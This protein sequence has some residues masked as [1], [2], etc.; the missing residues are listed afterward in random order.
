MGGADFSERK[1]A[2]VGQAS[3]CHQIFSLSHYPV[4]RLGL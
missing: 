1:H 3:A 2:Y 4:T